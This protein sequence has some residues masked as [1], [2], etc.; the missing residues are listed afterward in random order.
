[1]KRGGR[2]GGIFGN[3]VLV[4]EEHVF[5]ILKLAVRKMVNYRTSYF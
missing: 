1:M 2:G 4:V 3:A 5:R